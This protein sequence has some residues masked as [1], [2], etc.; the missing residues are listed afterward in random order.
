MQALA[1][2]QHS[3]V[4]HEILSVQ[5]CFSGRLQAEA[6]HPCTLLTEP[7]R[8]GG[9]ALANQLI[10]VRENDAVLQPVL[11]KI[12]VGSPLTNTCNLGLHQHTL[13]SLHRPLS[14]SHK[15]PV[16]VTQEEKSAF[17]YLITSLSVRGFHYLIKCFPGV[18]KGGLE[19]SLLTCLVSNFISFQTKI[20]CPLFIC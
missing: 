14:C 13:N 1:S 17:Y 9:G 15:H 16:E 7:S 12:S 18:G 3:S 11:R 10:R 4:T 2:I 8:K 20:L 5:A 19:E 6:M